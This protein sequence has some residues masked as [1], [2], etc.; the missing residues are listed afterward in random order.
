M[1]TSIQSTSHAAYESLPVVSMHSNLGTCPLFFDLVF[2]LLSA[3]L[4][5]FLKKSRFSF[6]FFLALFFSRH[7]DP[8]AD[9][10][11]LHKMERAI[12]PV[13]RAVIGSQLS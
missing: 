6:S 10:V 9:A 11:L 1:T 12:C 2:Y 5:I 4:I 3:L 13:A 8:P 7:V